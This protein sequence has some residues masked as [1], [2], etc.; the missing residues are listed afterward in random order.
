MGSEANATSAFHSQALPFGTGPHG[1][2]V[3]KPETP[4]KHPSSDPKPLNPR[5]KPE[6]S[7]RESCAL[8]HLLPT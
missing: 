8:H 1:T 2:G 4:K 5:L 6:P 7:V 3:L